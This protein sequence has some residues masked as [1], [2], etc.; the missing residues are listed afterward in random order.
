MRIGVVGNPR[1]DALREL[2][3]RLASRAAA[4]R[5]TICSEP[6]LRELWPSPCDPLQ[7]DHDPLDLLIT[8]GGDGTL[9]RGARLLGRREVPILGINL[10]RV[11]FLTTTTAEHMDQ[12][13]DA[14]IENR[15]EVEQRRKLE[16]RI[17]DAEGAKREGELAVNDVVVHKAQDTR[18][19]RIRLFVDGDEVGQYTVDGMIVATPAGS[20]AYTLSAGGPVLV[21]QVDAMVVTAICPHT[22][23]VRP[24]VVSGS[25]QVTLQV[26]P[27]RAKA[28][29][30]S[31]DG[32]VGDSLA[33][34][35]CVVIRASTTT[36]H[37]IRLGRES[38]F[39]RMRRKLHW[40]DLADRERL[41]RAD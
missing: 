9:L 20:T 27:T 25:S 14:V 16:S 12:A 11:G 40:G 41:N 18:I 33:P 30:V 26:E 35:D 1:Y 10:G 4:E 8:F 22:L 32:Q 19:I 37:L 5:I 2:I 38:F 29:L 24:I 23:S 31:Y 15:Y 39:S 17:V 21:P 36:V 13:L 34:N 7:H 6:A 3:A 28:V